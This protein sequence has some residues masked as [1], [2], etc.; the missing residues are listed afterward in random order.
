VDRPH[1][2]IV[3]ADAVAVYRPTHGDYVDRDCIGLDMVD[4][5]LDIVA[6]D[7]GRF[8]CGRHGRRGIYAYPYM[9]KSLI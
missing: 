2:P 4:R 7:D 6:V 3:A 5:Q 9:Q 8:T 1:R